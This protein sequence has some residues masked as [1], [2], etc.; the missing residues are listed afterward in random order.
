MAKTLY[1]DLDG[2]LVTSDTLLEALYLL[3]RENPLIVFSLPFWL[4]KGRAS[5]KE[6][7]SARVTIEPENLPVDKDFLAYLRRERA[8]GTKLVL[9]TAA[10]ES[11][12]EKIFD[13]IGLF[14]SYI[15]TTKDYNLKGENKLK[16]IKEAHPDFYYAGNHPVDLKIWK[17]AKGA[18]VVGPKSLRDKAEKLTE[19]VSWFPPKKGNFKILTKNKI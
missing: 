16:K 12:A 4:F 15:A 1:V 8:M 14:E 10:H 5:F 19:V 7:V 2:T 18:I 17:E 11:I 3:I 6:K 13:Y 9:A